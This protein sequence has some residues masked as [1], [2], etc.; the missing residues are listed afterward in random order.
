MTIFHSIVNGEM[1]VWCSAFLKSK[2]RFR[3]NLMSREIR[4]V[5]QR[6]TIRERDHGFSRFVSRLEKSARSFCWV[7]ERNPIGFLAGFSL[8]YFSASVT[9]AY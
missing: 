4:T 2:R 8:L 6:E 5:E 3:M 7:L 9:L 1:G